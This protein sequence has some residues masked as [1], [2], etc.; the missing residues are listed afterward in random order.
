MI[1]TIRRH[2][3][4]M[5]QQSPTLGP[6][7]PNMAQKRPQD[8][9]RQP[10]E[11]SKRALRKPWTPQEGPRRAPTSLP[12]GLWHGSRSDSAPNLAHKPLQN[13]PG[14]LPEPSRT[15]PGNEFGTYWG[16]IWDQVGPPNR[17]SLCIAAVGR[18][19]SA[20]LSLHTLRI[21]LLACSAPHFAVTSHN[22]R[23]PPGNQFGTD[24]GLI[25]DQ[26]WPSQSAL[27][28]YSSVLTRLPDCQRELLKCP[29]RL[30]DCSKTVTDASKIA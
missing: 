28:V 22:R 29:R 6:R 12:Q 23:T 11:G 17:L 26:V 27:P 4:M 2:G 7:R 19:C 15:P 24:W 20:S 10:Q 5:A 25:S 21:L 8:G 9:L 16:P 14:T 18:T 13:P 1:F 30:Q 3:D